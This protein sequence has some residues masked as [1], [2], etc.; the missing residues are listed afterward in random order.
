MCG[1]AGDQAREGLRKGTLYRD[2]VYFT[3]VKVYFS[4][5]RY[6]LQGK[7]AFCREK[8]Y[9]AGKGIFCRVYF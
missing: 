5:K 2:K 6:T 7:R 9:F 4:G 1:D 3:G 8:V